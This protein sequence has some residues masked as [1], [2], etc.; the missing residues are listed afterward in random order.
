MT[1]CYS[2]SCK[3]CHSKNIKKDGLR[4]WRQSYKCKDC[5]HIW[6]GAKRKRKIYVQNMYRDYALHKQTYTEL[7]QQ[8]HVC[9]K[10]IQHHLDTYTIPKKHTPSYTAIILI[11]DT[12]YFGD[13]GVMVF[14]DAQSKTILH[15]EIVHYETN[16]AYKNWIRKLQEQWRMIKAI[17]CDGRRWLLWWFGDIPTQMCQFHQQQIIKRYITKR[18][19]LQANKDLKHIVDRLHRTDKQAFVYELDKWYMKYE[20][21]MKEKTRDST[22]KQHYI[23][24]NTRSAYY[25]LKRNLEYLFI[26][27]QYYWV[28]DIPNTTNW[29]EAVFSHLKYKVNMHRGLRKDRKLKLISY[30]INI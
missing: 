13:I 30:L 10:T 8:Y 7:S 14:K 24:R 9:E 25:S 23:H 2:K 3:K 4:R 29:L 17:V 1:K 19:S 18:P 27:E 26:Y 15:F 28:I 21:F 5:K 16:D 11:I 22:W 6:I 12:T 20:V